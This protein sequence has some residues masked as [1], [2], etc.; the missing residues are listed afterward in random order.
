MLKEQMEL[1]RE[2]RDRGFTLVE[3]LL[4]IVIL[5][6]LAGIV[7]AAVGG[8]NT[9]SNQQACRAT[10]RTLQGA[11]NAW[12][13]DDTSATST[14]FPETTAIAGPPAYVAGMDA[15]VARLDTAGFIV[16]STMDSAVLA[17]TSSNYRITASGGG[18]TRPTIT[19]TYNTGGSGIPT[20]ACN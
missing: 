9:Q 2:G 18:T 16:R 15:M 11:V 17:G 3:L 12:N 4:V 20:V 7:V 1:R 14:A 13:A 19:G 8:L 5:G 10:V 6:V